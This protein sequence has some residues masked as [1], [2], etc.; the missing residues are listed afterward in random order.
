MVVWKR[1]IHDHVLP[2][3]GIDKTNFQLALVY[4]WADSGNII[5]Y[6]GSNP[7]ASRTRL[8]IVAIIRLH[9]RLITDPR[10]YSKLLEVTEGLHYLHSCGVVHGNLKGVSAHQ[11]LNLVFI[12]F[13]T[14]NPP[15]SGRMLILETRQMC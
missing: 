6:L 9:Y 5:Q 15:S 11:P 2:F 10:L 8:V 3:H 4:D 14:R 1:L 7:N 13:D 12:L